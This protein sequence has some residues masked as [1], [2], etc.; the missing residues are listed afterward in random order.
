[1]TSSYLVCPKVAAVIGTE[2]CANSSIN[3]SALKNA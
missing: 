2:S 1:M 3:Y